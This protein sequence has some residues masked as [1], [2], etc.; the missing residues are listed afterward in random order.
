MMIFMMLLV[1]IFIDVLG[2]MCLYYFEV[3]EGWLVV[4][5]YGSGLGVSGFSNFKYNYLVFV[6]VGYCVIVVDLFGYG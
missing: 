5:I 6:V 4:F 1:G 2:G 3:G